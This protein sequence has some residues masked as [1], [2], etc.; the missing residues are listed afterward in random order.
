MKALKLLPLF[1]LILFSGVSLFAQQ[2][3]ILYLV[4][5]DTAALGTRTP[6]FLIHGWNYDGK[7][8]P[9]TPQI[10]NN[11]RAYF[12]ATDTLRKSFKIYVVCYWANAVNDS[13]LSKL[14]RNKI[15][16]INAYNPNFLSR[17]IVLIGHS[18]GGLISRSFMKHTKFQAGPYAGQNCGER[19][20]Y[21]IT[22]G[23]PH[24]G[25]P[26]A[27]GPARDAKVAP[28]RL[29][30]LQFFENTI[31][32]DVKYNEVNRSD[33]R[34]DNYDNLMNYNTYP[35]EQNLWLLNVM[36]GNTLYDNKLIIYTAKHNYSTPMP[37]FNESQVFDIGGSILKLDFGQDS[38]GLVPVTSSDFIPHTPLKKYFYNNYDH[39]D[40]V[41][42]K[43][44]SDTSL[45]NSIK[46]DLLSSIVTAVMKSSEIAETFILGQNYPN[47]FNPVTKIMFQVSSQ[48]I[49]KLVVFDI[50][51]KEVATLVNESLQPGTYE[52][53]FDAG[54]LA[55][56]I[57]F[58]RLQA[59][60]FSE[61]KKMLMIK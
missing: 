3:T 35:D 53:T 54:N 15:D 11:F 51:G 25:S 21:L 28:V 17:K 58:Y 2:D 16:S 39:L 33:L 30:M 23:T 40:I 36:N 18:M 43:T 37:P 42:G 50:L 32:A 7:P 29:A 31:L 1:C 52:A 55:S 27:N 14:L 61:T 46:R 34:W 44:A 59:E 45:F 56:G 20:S 19:V 26:M 12:Q 60:G 8:A 10:W 24:H 38:D 13:T 47:P 5:G 49:V 6:L 41:E 22:L 57:Y 48:K 9:P 4:P